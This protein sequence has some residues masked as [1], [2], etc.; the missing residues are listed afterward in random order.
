LGLDVVDGAAETVEMACQATSR[1]VAALQTVGFLGEGKVVWFRDVA[2]LAD[3]VVGRSETV[4]TCVENLA[5]LITRGL[6]K[7][8]VLVI[9]SPKVDKRFAFYKACKTAGTIYEFVTAEKPWQAGNQ[10]RERVCEMLSESGLKMEEDALETFLGRVGGD[11]RQVANELEKLA[12]SVGKGATV[13]SLDVKELTSSSRSALAW[14]LADAFGRKNL[15]S[16]LDVLRRLLFQKESPIGLVILL[17][18][19]IRELMVYREALDRGWLQER[20]GYRGINFEWA[21]LSP[22]LET[23]FAQDFSKDPRA[24]HPYR[25][26]ILAGQAKL[27][28]QKDLRKCQQ[29]VIDAHRKLI[30][31]RVPQPVI[32]DLLLIRMLA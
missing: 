18:N 2:F 16:A 6:P 3:T 30:S 25:I 4:K 5:E 15:D 11:G 23:R 27:F 1:C 20:K 9:S 19:R 22:E 26:G 14:D 31:S 28:S 13:G 29:S 7:G 8:T 10:L 12:L 32:L 24:T 21:K 17:H